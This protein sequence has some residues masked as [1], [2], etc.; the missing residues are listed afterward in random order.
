MKKYILLAVA[1]ISI[2]ACNTADNN[3]D[4]SIPA[5]VTATIGESA[6]SRAADGEWTPGDCIGIS[7]TVGSVAGPY[8]NVKYTTAEGDENFDGAPLYFYKPMTL[9]AYYPFTG[10]E[11]TVPG[12][13]G[14]ITAD[15]RPVNQ[16]P[17]NRPLIDFLWDSQNEF[18]AANPDVN[19]T[20]S[21]KMSKLTV[22]FIYGEKV[23]VSDI[24]AYEIIGLRHD[25]TFNT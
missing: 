11:G 24:S 18:T 14:L 20:F 25:G 8:I 15:T 3:I 5:Q 19:F 12:N 9:T 6:R 10:E 22:S 2:T 13:D 17:E 23:D 1:A 16:T 21:H 7:S 4:D